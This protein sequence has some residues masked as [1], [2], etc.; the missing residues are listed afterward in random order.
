M[1]RKHVSFFILGS[2]W[3]NESNLTITYMPLYLGR[4]LECREVWR[5]EM[6]TLEDGAALNGKSFIHLFLSVSY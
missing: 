4:E 1:K 5:A 2:F 6:V 3:S